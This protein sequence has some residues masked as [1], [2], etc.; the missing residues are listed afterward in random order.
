MDAVFYSNSY[1]IVS[2][3]WK[4]FSVE[5]GSGSRSRE[6][7]LSNLQNTFLEISRLSPSMASARNIPH[8]ANI[9]KVP[10]YVTN[11]ELYE[12]HLVYSAIKRKSMNY[13]SYKRRIV[14]I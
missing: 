5:S 1:S 14:L 3:A 12:I 10:W 13:L 7:A 8:H 11:V 2:S 6:G 9:F 4:I